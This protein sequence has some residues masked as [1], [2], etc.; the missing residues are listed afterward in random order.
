MPFI[1]FGDAS[2]SGGL[3]VTD[4]GYMIEEVKMIRFKSI[5]FYKQFI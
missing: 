3:K 1:I 4:G 5:I 2:L